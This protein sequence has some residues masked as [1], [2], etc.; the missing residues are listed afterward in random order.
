MYIKYI[1]NNSGVKP[2][3]LVVS[4]ELNVIFINARGQHS[5]GTINGV[6]TCHQADLLKICILF[7]LVKLDTVINSF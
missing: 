3:L 1:C 7:T 6:H 5:C 2:I 4:H